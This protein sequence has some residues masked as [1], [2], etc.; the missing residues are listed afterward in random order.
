MYF[1]GWNPARPTVA[2]SGS[3]VFGLTL[4]EISAQVEVQWIDSKY[5]PVHWIGLAARIRKP[6][7]SPVRLSALPPF[8]EPKSNY[9]RSTAFGWPSAG[10]MSLRHD[11]VDRTRSVLLRSVLR[12]V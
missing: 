5:V 3:V 11:A 8:V 4:F 12:R 10:P 9:E 6:A 2:F 7:G 1:R